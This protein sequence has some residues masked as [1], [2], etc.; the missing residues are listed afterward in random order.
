MSDTLDLARLEKLRDLADRAKKAAGPDPLAWMGPGK[1][2]PWTRKRSTERLLADLAATERAECMCD[3]YVGFT[4]GLHRR[5]DDIA[6]AL[7]TRAAS[8]QARNVLGEKA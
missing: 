4:C 7:R 1:P 5:A 3:D 2:A 6:H 8:I